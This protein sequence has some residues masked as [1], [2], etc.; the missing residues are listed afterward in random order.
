MSWGAVDVER[1]IGEDHPAI[2]ISAL[3]GRL[4]LSAFYRANESSTEARGASVLQKPFAGDP[5]NRLRSQI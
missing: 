2:D 1:L 4:N 5:R 3:V